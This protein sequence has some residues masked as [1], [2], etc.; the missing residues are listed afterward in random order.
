MAEQ[1][2]KDN[3]ALS[4]YLDTA[5]SIFL[6]LNNDHT[7]EFANRKAC[8]V[9][10]YSCNKI[11]G[12]NWF[13]NFIPKRNRKEL[14]VMFDQIMQG[15]IEPPDGYE[16]IVLTSDGQ[17]ILIQWRNGNLFDDDGKLLSIISSG[18]DITENKAMEETIKKKEAKTSALLRTLPDVM[19][20][21]D[22]YGNYLEVYAPANFQL[23]APYDDHIG[24]NIDTILPKK[25]CEII[26]RGFADCERTKEAQTV[27]Y[28][29][30]IEGKLRHIE[31]RIIQTNEGNFLSIIRD[32]TN[33]KQ[34]ELLIKE[35]E[36][37]FR[38]AMLATHDGFYDFIPETNKGWY[39]Q[40]YI[41]LFKPTKQ[42]NWWEHN[43]HPDD[44]ERVL[45]T[46]NKALTGNGNYWLSE[47]RLK[48]NNKSYLHIE[49][50]GHIVR[51]QEGKAIRVLG[52]VADISERKK[53]EQKLLNY[54]T[55]LEKKVM[56]RTHEL[57]ATV[58]ELVKSNLN[59]QDQIQITKIAENKALASQEMFSAIA[60]NFPRGIITVIDN[61][62]EILY[63]EGEG[64]IKMGLKKSDL[65]GFKIDEIEV[66]SE[67]RR[68]RLKNDIQKT[69]TGQHLSFEIECNN[70][71]FIVNTTPLLD[72][73]QKITRALFVYNNITEQKKVEQEIRNTLRKEQEL[74][75]LKSR[76][77]AMASHEFRTP[78][79]AINS[80]AILLGKQNEHGK[81]EK[82]EKYIRQIKSSVKNLVTILNDFLSLSKLEEGKVV[83]NL[84]SLDI[85]EFSKSI[86]KE[87]EPNKKKGQFIKLINNYTAN[88]ADLD[89]KLLYHILANLLS[90]AIKYSTENKDIT[91]QVS[92]NNTCLF[93]EVTDQGI[94]IPD[95]DQ[96]NMFSRFYR[97]ENTTNIEGTGL[98]LNIVKQYTEL[99]N[100]KVSLK[101]KLNEG[102]TFSVELPINQK[103]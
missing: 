6:V 71:A 52:A 67:E 11:I 25:V 60:R 56:Q 7:I 55:E 73:N 94:G 17:E 19:M 77:I 1:Q 75:E 15:K 64:L 44:K 54:S 101:S 16:N 40:K 69:L 45:K 70:I 78:L 61:N 91:L 43:I 32:V 29:F 90:N 23:A 76:F 65:K 27:E 66:Y 103:K 51:N 36:E 79:T 5:S 83:T 3:S 98:G 81:E 97:A 35:K 96:K 53:A 21:Y 95:K 24:Q 82:R 46:V 68:S 31:S 33:I 63:T 92:S 28:F 13:D 59:F 88:N 100:G 10:G 12:M 99:M 57:E 34:N 18:V 42:K 58:Q 49:D 26:R 4:Q 85:I 80:S 74:N 86:I 84:E 62:F 9:L 93:L 47:Y 22:K 39:N 89:P 87:F 8:E 37:R 14:T 38:L 50:R 2:N 48:S 72:E 20:V 102:S 41:D 30:T